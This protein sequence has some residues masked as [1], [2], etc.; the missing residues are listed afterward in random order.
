MGE[1]WWRGAVVYQ[2]YPRSFADASGDGIG[3]LAGIIDRLDHVADL[4]AD[5]I[6]LSPFFPSPNRDFGYDISE[7]CDVAPEL[8]DLATFDRLVETAHDRGLRVVIDAVLNHTSDEHPWFIESS[9]STDGPKA[10]WYIWHDGRERRGEPGKRPPNNWRGAD[11]VH[12]AWA[13]HSGR[14]QW[15]LA[16]F[17][18]AQPDLNWRNP[19]VRAEM[20]RVIRFWLD[21]GVA[22]FRFDMFGAIMKDAELRDEPWRPR[23]SPDL[24]RIRVT[25]RSRTQNTQDTYELAND[26]RRLCIEHRG[27]DDV[28]LIGECFGTLPALARYTEVGKGFTHAFLFDVLAFRY[29]ARWFREAIDR[30]EASFAPPRDPAYVLENHDRTRLVDRV[31]GDR[32]KARVLATILCTVRGQATIYQGQELGM[33]NTYIPLREAQDVLAKRF[34]WIPEAVNRR[35]PERINRDEVRTP[36]AWEPGP[37]GGFSVADDV[38]PWLPLT[39]ELDTINVA[40]QDGDPDSMLELYRALLGLRRER[41][42]LRR[43]RLDLVAGVPHGLLAYLRSDGD[44]RVLVGANLTDVRRTLPTGGPTRLLV[45]TDAGVEL[46]EWTVTLPGNTAVVLELDGSAD[47]APDEGERSA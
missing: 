18:R 8:G 25:D 13:F 19:E 1:P 38:T 41:P 32:T 12:S 47:A 15:Y 4:G 5:A 40:T 24:Q 10:D 26:I 29:D 37:T 31:G 3:D 11:M 23:L 2:I 43:G 45:G 36:M 16:T 27:N 22:G 7:Y 20:E 9:S 42:A 21:R 33:A 14:G 17:D 34:S 35:L 46:G 39:P 6:W 44:E 30:Y 28:L